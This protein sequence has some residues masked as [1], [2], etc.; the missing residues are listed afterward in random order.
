MVSVIPPATRVSRHAIF[1]AKTRGISIEE[2]ECDILRLTGEKLSWKFAGL[3]AE[4]CHQGTN[5]E[6]A[7]RSKLE[8]PAANAM[9]FILFCITITLTHYV[10]VAEILGL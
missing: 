10:Y 7:I 3:L 2:P 9:K 1:N 4:N 6:T 5:T 8:I